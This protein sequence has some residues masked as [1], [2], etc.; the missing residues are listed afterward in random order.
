MLVLPEVMC[1]SCQRPHASPARGHR[2][3]L[4]N[5]E[6][7]FIPPS[8]ENFSLF[9][10]PRL[11][12]SFQEI[13][14]KCLANVNEFNSKLKKHFLSKLSSSVF[15]QQVDS[16]DLGSQLTTNLCINCSLKYSISVG[17]ESISTF[18]NSGSVCE[19]YSERVNMQTAIF[20]LRN[21][22]FN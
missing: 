2:A 19:L 11:W 7:L 9:S 17:R 16:K 21:N 6:D 4:R 5:N 1:K 3:V 8:T 12:G 15:L 13:N 18:L 20:C 10:F 14:I 22:L